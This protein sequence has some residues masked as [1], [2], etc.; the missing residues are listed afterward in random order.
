M[1]VN[2]QGALLL[3]IDGNIHLIQASEV[4]VRPE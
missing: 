4:S 2:E 1:G 3:D